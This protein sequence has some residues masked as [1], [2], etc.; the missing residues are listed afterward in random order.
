[1][2]VRAS[3]TL[4]HKSFRTNKQ[5]NSD[6]SQPS[7]RKLSNYGSLLFNLSVTAFGLGKIAFKGSCW[8]FSFSK[9]LPSPS[10]EP[11]LESPHL[12]VRKR[13]GSVNGTYRGGIIP[14]LRAAPLLLWYSKASWYRKTGRGFVCFFLGGSFTLPETNIYNPWKSTPGKGGSYWKPPFFQAMLVSGNLCG[15]GTRNILS[16]CCTTSYTLRG[17]LQIS[18]TAG[19]KFYTNSII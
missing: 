19:L 13:W 3:G 4:A 9:L 10:G 11:C 15:K 14:P 2:G 12:H 5:N 17:M 6:T 8:S 7:R 1:M 16:P 18:Q